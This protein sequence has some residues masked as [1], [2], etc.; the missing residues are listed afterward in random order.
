MTRRYPALPFLA[1]VIIGI[2]TADLLAA[3]SWIFLSIGFAA[4]LVALALWAKGKTVGAVALTVV[5][6]GALAGCHYA[7]RYLERGPHHVANNV[8]SK[9]ITRVFGRIADWP[10]LR[11]DHTDY[12]VA[13]DSVVTDQ[14]RRVDG[15]I[16]LRVTD[17][18]TAL[19]RG[20]RVEFYGRV[21]LNELHPEDE[22][23]TARRM[24]L[25]EICG[26][27]YLPTLLNVRVDR[28][29][30]VGL[31]AVVDRVR[32]WILNVFEQS[33]SPESAAMASGFLLGETRNISPKVYGMFRDSGTLHVLAVSGSNVA[34]VLLFVLVALRP[35]GVKQPW[36]G[37][38][39][40]AA[41]LI[42][43]LLSY[44]QPSVIRASVMAAFVVLAGML[45]REYD[46]NHIV[47]L[48]VLVILA[49]AP[50][51]LFDVGFQLSVVTAWG[52]VLLV[53]PLSDLFGKWHNKYW[54]RWLVFPIMI[55]VIAQICSAPLIAYY[56]GKVPLVSVPANLVIVPLTSIAVI[57]LMGVLA[58][59]L[60]L[61]ILGLFL[62]TL[63]D[64]I[65]RFLVLA[66]QWFQQWQWTS[67]ETGPLSNV[68]LAKLWIFAYFIL[69]VLAIFGLG[70]KWARRWA[71]IG[72]ALAINAVLATLVFMQP[73]QAPQIRFTSL[74]GG[75]IALVDQPGE[76]TAD[77]IIA[78]GR[79][80]IDDVDARLIQ[81]V[82][83]LN[84]IKKLR[85]LYVLYATF[86]VIDDL[87]RIAIANQCAHVYV[88]EGNRAGFE[89]YLTYHPE[90]TSPPITYFGGEASADFGIG[91]RLSENRIDLATRHRQFV[92]CSGTES[93]EESVAAGEAA[94]LTLIVANRW[95]P[96]PQDWIAL[97]RKGVSRIICSRIEQLPVEADDASGPDDVDLVL[98]EFTVDLYR[99]GP[100]RL[101]L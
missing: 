13:V 15:R 72:V 28:R 97:R 87:L 44:S 27:V 96:T 65:L 85:H 99:T 3:P 39:L 16:L 19:Q 42:F 29:P 12:V 59:Y 88:A 34:L 32:I 74:P 6:I 31:F 26:A 81:P 78:S 50:S 14:L 83:D 22:H 25:R 7:I 77:M 30:E 90:M 76:Y 38:A 46:L 49:V 58:A 75:I 37:G 67:V 48:S 53:K 64:P 10:D 52:L 33:L 23:S 79:V 63:I 84:R 57:G 70:R 41:I 21:Y 89:D 17:T 101:P 82:L 86:D 73:T 95:N 93:I 43:A 9:K 80:R 69:V 5:G 36:R 55:S 8:T 47:S 68:P 94:D 1:A 11:T 62:G 20:D 56:F 35:F 71:I 45:G 18:T 24:R 92:F 60:I 91:Y 98:P 40:L 4:I 61:P 100:Y 2:V 54:Y 66:L 51:Q